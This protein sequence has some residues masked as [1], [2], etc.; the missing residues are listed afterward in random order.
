MRLI[1][2]PINGVAVVG[3]I[4]IADERQNGLVEDFDAV[5]GG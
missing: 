5:V 4:R 1:K 3:K 2:R